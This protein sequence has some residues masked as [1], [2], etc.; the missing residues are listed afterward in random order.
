MAKI[1]ANINENVSRLE[2][3]PKPCCLFGFVRAQEELSLNGFSQIEF[4]G[5]LIDEPGD[6]TASK[7]RQRAR[8]FPLDGLRK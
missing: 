8:G 2:A 7:T 5:R 3:L 4:E 1:R 6:V